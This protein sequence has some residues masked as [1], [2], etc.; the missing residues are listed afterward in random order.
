MTVIEQ[1]EAGRLETIAGIVGSFPL[2]IQDVCENCLVGFKPPR[3]SRGEGKRNFVK[4]TDVHV[5]EKDYIQWVAIVDETTPDM[6][7][8]LSINIFR[9]N[10][11]DFPQQ[12]RVGCAI[13]FRDLKVCKPISFSIPISKLLDESI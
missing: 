13:G 11:T 1:L 4:W 9:R 5:G 8:P 7:T 10:P 6:D 12:L 2:P 3:K